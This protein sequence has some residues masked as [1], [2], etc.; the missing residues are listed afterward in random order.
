[1]PHRP[2]TSAL[3]NA[4]TSPPSAETCPTPVIAMASATNRPSGRFRLDDEVG[5]RR[6]R[7]ESPLPYFF[8]R[9]GDVESLF[10]QHDQ[11]ERVD[12]IEPQAGTVRRVSEDRRL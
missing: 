12:R 5:E 1:M 2:S 6:D 11:L 3:A 10:D 7:S 4:G 9:N 8:V